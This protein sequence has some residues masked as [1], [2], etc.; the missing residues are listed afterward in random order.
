MDFAD[1]ELAWTNL[2]RPVR[3]FRHAWSGADRDSEK[4]QDRV[5]P[6]QKPIALCLWAFEKYG[7]DGDLIFD[8]FLGSGPSLKA[9]EQSSRTVVGC[10]L[11]PAYV[12]HLIEWAEAE[13]LTVERAETPHK[14]ETTP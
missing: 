6:T 9:A 2:S 1:A 12:D 5:H 7:N 8:P 14:A 11:A 3:C 4:G 13:G 10:E